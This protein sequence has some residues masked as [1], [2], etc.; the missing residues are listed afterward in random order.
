MELETPHSEPE[1]VQNSS[2]LY[3]SLRWQDWLTLGFVSSTKYVRY[4]VPSKKW[5]NQLLPC[6]LKLT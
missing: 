3:K 4:G 2:A 6:I 1:G 5:R